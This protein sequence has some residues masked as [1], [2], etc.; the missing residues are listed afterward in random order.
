VEW[1]IVTGEYPPQLGGVG[2]YTYQVCHELAKGGDGVHVWSPASQLEVSR[3]EIWQVHSLPRGFGWRW[4]REL[5]WRLRNYTGPRNILIQYVPHMYGWKSMNVGFCAWICMQRKH[6]VYVMFHEVAFPFQSGQRFRHRLLAVVHRMMAWAILRFV[7]HSFTSTEP[8]FSLLR[9]LGR[10]DTPIS[11]LRICSNIPQESYQAEG[12]PSRNDPS[13]LFTVGIFSNFGEELRELLGPIIGCVLGN[14]KIEV[15]LLGPGEEFRQSLA[16]QYPQAADR[17]RSTGR[18]GVTE[19]AGHMRNCDAL[20]QVY[21]EG[22]SAGRGTLIGALASGVPVVTTSGPATDR[23]LLDSDT[24]LFCGESPQSIREALE[25]LRENP[26]LAQELGA[27]AQRLY[28]EW[29]QPAV[30]VSTLR[31]VSSSLNNDKESSELQSRSVRAFPISKLEDREPNASPH[32]ADARIAD[33]LGG[34]QNFL[35]H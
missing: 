20:L 17:I 27:A 19:V 31:D 16:A 25:Q 15:A 4:L 14:P 28:R 23:L 9:T 26:A 21:P 7:R 32:S 29:F 18:L 11:M 6:N 24:M 30:I 12:R 8:Y 10:A 35:D 3:Q 13:V 34:T 1:H 33:E 2:D 5:D 22:A